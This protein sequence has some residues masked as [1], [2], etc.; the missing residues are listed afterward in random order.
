MI[1]K[2]KQLCSSFAT[3]YEVYFELYE[4][5]KYV[6]QLATKYRAASVE[7][8]DEDSN[9]TRLFGSQT[10]NKHENERK[11]RK[12]KINIAGLVRCLGT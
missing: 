11:N 9:S 1:N 5:T 12:E 10:L 4:L 3:C 6:L 2:H 8:R 7:C